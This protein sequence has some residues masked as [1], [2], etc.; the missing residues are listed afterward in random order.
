MDNICSRVPT[1][2]YQ[3]SKRR[4]LNWIHQNIKSLKFSTVLDGFGGTG[5]VSYLFKMMGKSVTYN[6]ILKSNYQIGIGLIENDRIVL[7]KKDIDFLIYENGFDYLAF[8]QDSFK[9]IYYLNEEN[10]W[11]DIVVQNIT[12][13]SE[14]YEGEMLRKKK[15]LAYHAL[16]QACLCKRPYNLFHR[17]N[18][19]MRTANVE[20]TF[21]N[22]KTWD[23][24]FDRLFMKFCRE[25][26]GKI[27]SNKC[28]N[29]AKCENILKIKDRSFDLVYLDPPYTK[30]K[31]DKPVDYHNLYHFLEGLTDYKNWNKK[32]DYT[33]KNR[34]LLKENLLWP[35]DS[36]K[37]NLIK[38]FEMF[39]DSLIVLSYCDPCYPS[40]EVIVEYLYQYKNEVA[41]SRIEHSYKLNK[42]KKNGKKLHEVLIIGY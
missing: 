37:E 32:I 6:D 5:S 26:S 20:R 39:S 30:S 27:F 31:K 11:L 7:N 36:V 14:K 3:G 23:A 19:Y 34:P 12:M 40:L 18:L 29:I 17:K 15:A 1:T 8:I 33:R 35:K 22:K 16:F 42:L 24:P 10:K 13:L 38:I 25:I 21:G 28:C 41:V 9:D 2:R 4:L